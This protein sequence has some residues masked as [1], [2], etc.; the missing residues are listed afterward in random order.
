MLY[1]GGAL[2]C[3]NS[4]T[5][6]PLYEHQRPAGG[7]Y[8]TAS[9]WAYNGRVFCLNE[10]GVTF[11]VRAGDKFELLGT[12]KLADDD[13][14]LA[15]PGISGDRLLLRTAARLYCIAG[16]PSERSESPTPAAAK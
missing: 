12:N 4:R 7:K 15:T 6:E 5:G 14:C 3:F 8:F 1:D 10:D 9:P 13:M 16:K 11:V 2:S